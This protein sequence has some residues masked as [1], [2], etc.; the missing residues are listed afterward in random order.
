MPR[1]NLT[2]CYQVIGV[3]ALAAAVLVPCR[4]A[5]AA[6]ADQQVKSGQLIANAIRNGRL[7]QAESMLAIRKA[8]LTDPSDPEQEILLAELA[9]AKR[10]DSL[11]FNNFQKHADN[12]EFACRAKEGMGVVLVRRGEFKPA[13]RLLGQVTSDCSGHGNAWHHLGIALSVLKKWEGARYAFNRA[14]AESHQDRGAILNNIGQLHMD[15]GNVEKALK[16]FK[17]ARNTEPENNRFQNNVDIAGAT[18]GVRPQ[19]LSRD[20]ASRW[21]ERL[22]NSATA[23]IDAGFDALGKQLLAELLVEAPQTPRQALAKLDP[24]Q[25]LPAQK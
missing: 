5:E 6:A 8:R 13:A 23:A 24:D 18:I 20:S 22:N 10:Q 21:A 3:F 17:A 12:S 19:R 16:F 2:F 7:V 14:L 15:Q 25:A 9:L 4:S 11:A 1:L